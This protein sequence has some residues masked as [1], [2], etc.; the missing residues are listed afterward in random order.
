VPRGLRLLFLLLP[1]GAAAQGLDAAR[2][3][4]KQGALREAQKAYEALLPQFRGKD[5]ASLAS[6]LSGLGQIALAQ[7]DYDLA[8]TRTN[9]AKAL[10]RTIG[11]FNGEMKSLNSS[12]AAQIY[13]ADYP[14]ALRDFDEALAIARAHGNGEIEVDV[15]NNIGSIHY[16]RAS[17]LDALRAYRAA[18][19]TIEISANQPWSAHKRAITVANTAQLFLRLGQEQQALQLYR[20]LGKDSQ[21]LTS[22]EQ[23]R[24]LINQGVLF[25]R[26]EDPQKALE[27]YSAASAILSKEG[28]RDAEIGVLK[29]IG[30]VQALDLNNLPAALQAFTEA[31]K[32][33]E[34]AGNKREVMQARLYLG[35][36]QLLRNDNDPAQAEFAAALTAA[37]ALDSTDEQWKA[38]YGL[39]RALRAT[40]HDDLAAARFRESVAVIESSRAKL[41][42]PS[43]K[44]D[45]LSDKRE[46]YDALIE[47]TLPSADSAAVFDLLERSRARNFQDRLGETQPTL[48]AVQARLDKST[49]LLELWVG[50]K[51]KA[52]VLWITSSAAKIVRIAA[53]GA[54]LT[55]LLREV[56]SGSGEA[57]KAL[58]SSVGDGLLASVEPLSQK[59]LSQLVVVPDGQLS[60]LPF[61]VLAPLAGPPLVE[62]FAISYLPSASLLLRE[63]PRSR[64]W[65]LPWKL[66]LLAF[67]DPRIGN[68]AGQTAADALAGPELQSLLPASGDE[69][70][71]I[72]RTCT[73]RSELHLGSDD[74]K[75][76]LTA[77]PAVPLLHL[78]THATADL[79]SP[80]RSRIL[81]SPAAA[82]DRADYLFLK[83]VYGLDLRGVDLAILSAC[84]T[85]RGKSIRGEGVQGFGRALL[86]AG[87]RSSITALWRVA[88]EPSREFMQQ[89]YYEL[90]HGAPK[91]EALRTAKLSFL[92]S[93]TLLRHP[94]FWAPFVL[95]GD[96]QHAIPRVLPWSYL[97]GAAGAIAV[98]VLILVRRRTA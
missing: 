22:S 58:A 80:E 44:T 65:S 96:G 91:A 27:T 46:V 8:L 13:R 92:R 43:L 59:E 30:I 70:R 7:G 61:D 56:S 50:P 40:G 64:S 48:P 90:N 82:G 37:K 2:T 69:A 73:G 11:D 71:A 31:L 75:R 62:R 89:L 9:E 41:Q 3:L 93:S 66:Q 33:A 20:D 85:E 38:L 51:G 15:L 18:S 4:Q 39:G 10:F 88:D 35:E 97:L 68:A 87:A 17:Y 60:Q 76:Y 72:A 49:L 36:T 84:D 79:T 52:A 74:L 24:L 67:A 47:L 26:L 12:G 55:Q 45:F 77:A 34:Q 5:P 29:N 95:N 83:E 78:A 86:A 19:A 42:L 14:A 25:R 28:H 57:W 94:R 1:L 63:T 98:V 16:L 23:A 81:F 32:L 54:E 21:S 6:A 53:P